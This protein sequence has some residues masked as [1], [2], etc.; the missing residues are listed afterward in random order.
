MTLIYLCN[1]HLLDIR[2]NLIVSSAYVDQL[3]KD[4][5]FNL[6]VCYDSEYNP[7]VQKV[8]TPLCSCVQNSKRDPKKRPQ[9]TSEFYC[10]KPGPLEVQL[11]G[12]TGT[13]SSPRTSYTPPPYTVALL[14]YTLQ[15]HELY[16]NLLTG[17]LF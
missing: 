16:S 8:C 4:V 17:T 14:W 10:W 5:L 3:I 11:H 13:G 9:P 15:G 12:P 1:E 7:P 2:N 6:L